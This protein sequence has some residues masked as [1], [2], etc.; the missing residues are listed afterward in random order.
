[1]YVIKFDVEIKFKKQK[2]QDLKESIFDVY[3]ARSG[4]NNKYSDYI[5][6]SWND[7][8]GENLKALYAIDE[9]L[10]CDEVRNVEYFILDRGRTEDTNQKTFEILMLSKNSDISDS[11]NKVLKDIKSKLIDLK[12]SIKLILENLA[13]LYPYNQ[14]SDD[15]LSHEIALK[16][17]INSK[18]RLNKR[19]IFIDLLIIIF[20]PILF[21]LRSNELG[22]VGIVDSI[23]ASG[24]FYI[25]LELFTKFPTLKQPFGKVIE[26]EELSNLFYTNKR[27]SSTQIT[28]IVS[29]DRKLEDPEL[30]DPKPE[31]PQLKDPKLEVPKVEDPE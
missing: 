11:M 25:F 9:I 14:N 7:I 26:S 15:I 12:V 30:E 13:L 31:V 10:A 18:I 20:I 2:F 27:F 4:L 29:E 28:Q 6:K 17:R 3:K 16:A 21:L 19:E 8:Q 22:N 5:R 1:M 24:I 23:I